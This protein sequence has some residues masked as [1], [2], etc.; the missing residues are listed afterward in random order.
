MK[1][2][3]S[4][5]VATSVIA[6]LAGVAVIAATSTS[7]AR[8]LTAFM[9]QPQAPADYACFTNNGGS[10]TN[11]CATTKQYCVTLPVDGSNHI[12]E[13]T[14]LAPDI[15]HNIACFAQ[16][17][18]RD[19]TNAGFTGLKSPGIFGS[20]QVLSFPTLTVPTAGSLYVC[21]NIAQTARLHS[22]NY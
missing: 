17:N 5:G 11:A 22:V 16:A 14:V 20:A 2:L 6:G 1:N 8:S 4:Y 3:L 18:A 9:G 7:E 12:V 19:N 15:N 21:C 10:V 13:V